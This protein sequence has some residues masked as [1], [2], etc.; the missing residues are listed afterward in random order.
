MNESHTNIIINN[1]NN[2]LV[3][4]LDIGTNSLNDLT[5][6]REIL[7]NTENNINKIDKNLKI[8]H[9][10]VTRMNSL[11]KRLSYLFKNPNDNI[12]NISTTDNQKHLH[13]NT[14]F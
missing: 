1:I 6:Q 2:Q 5:S 10:I 9:K 4:T 8:S 12:S 14:E 11:S 7:I 13:N 3:H